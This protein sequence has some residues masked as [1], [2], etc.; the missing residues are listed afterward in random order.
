[1]APEQL[2][3]READVRSDIWSLGATL[4]EMTTGR[5]AFAGSSTASVISAI[6]REEPQPLA[7]LVPMSPPALDRL[8][9]T[10][11]A[12]DPDERWQSAADVAR[13]LEWMSPV[14]ID[15]DWQ[16][17]ASHLP[18]RLRSWVSLALGLSSQLPPSSSRPIASVSGISLLR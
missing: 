6:M 8:V 16:P 2:E 4:Y 10:C 9:R 14:E 15:S 3:G 12:K 17:R 1:M 18:T 11:V 13:T 5:R 7:E